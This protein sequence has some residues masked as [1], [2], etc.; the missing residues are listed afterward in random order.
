MNIEAMYLTLDETIANAQSMGY[1]TFTT[2][3]SDYDKLTDV[4]K[5]IVALLGGWFATYVDLTGLDD[6]SKQSAIKSACYSKMLQLDNWLKLHAEYYQKYMTEQEGFTGETTSKS[7]FLDTPE[8]KD[9]YEGNTHIT[10]ITKNVSQGD[11]QLK[12]Q[13]LRN[14]KET[15]IKEFRKTWLTP[16]EAL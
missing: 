12:L 11:N 13:Y 5:T 4:P 3:L 8:T 9:D 16:K 15:F 6:S 2:C 1:T 14:I 10:N 7:S